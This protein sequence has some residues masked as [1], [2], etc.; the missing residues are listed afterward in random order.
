V[1]PDG[2]ILVAGS[3]P[4]GGI[5]QLTVLRIDSAGNGDFSFGTGGQTTLQ[6]D[7]S[8]PSTAAAIAL[9]S[10]Q[11]IV[12][13]GAVG[14]LGL[15]SSGFR[16]V[17]VARLNTDGSPDA[18]FSA[19]GVTTFWDGYSSHGY[20]VAI[21]SGD[22]I[23][24]G[25]T[26]EGAPGFLGCGISACAFIRPEHAALFRLQGGHGAVASY[27]SERR[28]IEYYYAAFGHY[29]ISAT[30][31]EIA[32]LDT[33]QAW[34]RTGQS[35]KVWT[36]GGAGLSPVCRFFSGENF[37][38]KSSHFYT[39]YPDECAA[40]KA[41]T[42]WEFEGNVFD[43]Q[44]PQGTSG[45]RSCPAGTA[46]LYRLYNNGQ[47]GAPNHRYTESLAIFNQMLAQGWIFEARHRPKYLPA[48][49]LCNASRDQHCEHDACDEVESSEL[50][51]G[52]DEVRRDARNP[53]I[54]HALPRRRQRAAGIDCAARVLDD[55]H[56][57]SGFP[58]VDGGVCD[59]EVGR[60]ASQ[61]HPREAAL[62]QITC[63]A[64]E[65][66]AVRL[67]KRRVAVDF[68]AIALAHD[69]FR[70]GYRECG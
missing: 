66:H 64:G 34:V 36:E 24:V 70:L 45:Q 1:Q 13:A 23:L 7:A 5:D 28:A 58:C 14:D 59:T 69:E 38:P 68:A 10:R 19:H 52:R 57:E 51:W 3:V 40:L 46:P 54:A 35:F 48:S 31:Y 15:F 30:P 63:E 61:K 53:C 20:A 67:A 65:R 39:P 55:D 44:L 33:R 60:Q 50:A 49:L 47:G 21:Q 16:Q 18:F 26:S 9:D 43:L 4:V 42:V 25:S 27:V 29:F 2:N 22:R 37:A 62:A 8:A 56:L 6:V 12:V 11:R 17:M 32:S 41:G